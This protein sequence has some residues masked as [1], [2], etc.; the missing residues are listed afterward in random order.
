MTGIITTPVTR[1]AVLRRASGIAALGAAAPLLHGLASASDAAAATGTD[2]YRALVC[3]FLYGGNDHPNTL[4]PYDRVN[5]GRYS[6]IRGGGSF[7]RKDLADTVLVPRVP[8]VLTD[9]LEYAVAPYLPRLKVLFDGGKLAPVLNVGSLITPVTRT[10][11][12]GNNRA[13]Y[14]LPPKL[15]S[16]NDQQCYWQALGSEGSSV[17][18]GGRIGDYAM[19]SND[20]SL[21]TCI[22]AS[23]NAV[24]VSGDKVL[25][26][27]V[28]PNG[29][30]PVIPIRD[31]KYASPAMAA[32][33][34][35]LITRP[36]AHA[37]ENELG[38]LARRSIE[39]EGIVNGALSKLNLQ[40]S[41]DLVPGDNSLA[42][43]LGIVA[44][45][46]AAR[47]ELGS[48]RQVF[49]VSLDGFDHHSDLS[50]KHNDL[51][52]KLD[53]A[54]A[55]FYIATVELGVA[56]QVTTFTASD[57]GRTLVNNG[58]GSDHGWGSHH[59]II[60]GAVNGGRYYG[61]APQTSATSDD[62]VGQGRLLP[63]TAIDQY[64]ATLARW[65]G[66]PDSE[67]ATILPNIGN[68]DGR[69]L[70]FV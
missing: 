69:Y 18:W 21:L 9:D 39:M 40:S 57:F 26:Y 37:L 31:P 23:G 28:S 8:Q 16:H 47:N 2:D 15:F 43:Q 14:P 4:I 29:A 56:S 17:G 64:A 12:D 45:L 33:L 44:R 20:H 59:F 58:D 67:M 1:R 35:L 50:R 70:D 60:G 52:Q 48:R 66:V 41:F 24:F 38:I 65:F 42:D 27:Q 32:A 22:S 30:I 34:Q 11:F 7:K 55:A 62:Q 36:S 51:M 54:V 46:I 63:S 53:E 3:V 5:Y 6:K 10:Q 49:F 19:G 68:F 61:T 25:Q 13:L